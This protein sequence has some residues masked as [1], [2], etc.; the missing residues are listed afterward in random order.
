MKDK[1]IINFCWI[2][3]AL[4]IIIQMVQLGSAGSYLPHKQNTDFNLVVTSNNATSCEFTYIQY[5]NGTTIYFND[6]M[7]PSG[8]DFDI[9]VSAT[10]FQATGSQC[11]GITCTDGVG[12]ESGSVCREITP[13]GQFSEIGTSIFYIGLLFI[14]IVFLIVCI[15]IFMKYD[16][17]LARVGMIGLG[18]LLLIAI[19]FIGW[20]MASDFLTSAPFLVEMLR[21]LFFVLIVGFFPLVIGGFAWYVLM[22]FKIKEIERLMGKG[23]SEDEARRRTA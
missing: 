20:N 15:V 18:Y 10:E 13:N 12:Y 7:N 6:A 8:R 11:M 4:M 9:I 17:L 3:T 23:F 5:P 22:L 21:I 2:V 16:N 19:T 1:T 14:L